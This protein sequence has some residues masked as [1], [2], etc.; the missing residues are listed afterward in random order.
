MEEQMTNL[1]KL[2]SWNEKMLQEESKT[3]QLKKQY[4]DLNSE[5]NDITT[6]TIPKII[7][8]V[9]NQKDIIEKL[10][11]EI[12]DQQKIKIIMDN[13]FKNKLKDHQNEINNLYAIVN[14]LQQTQYIEEN[15][16]TP[17]DT[18]RSKKQKNRM[19]T[20]E[21]MNNNDS[22]MLIIF[23]T[24]NDTATTIEN[25]RSNNLC[26]DE[27]NHTTIIN[28]TNIHNL[29]SNNL[30]ISPIVMDTT[31]IDTS[32][33][34]SPQFNNFNNESLITFNDETNEMTPINLTS[35]FSTEE[36]NENDFNKNK[37]LGNHSP[38]YDT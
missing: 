32:A 31:V 24:G 30:P 22:S 29:E 9:L 38:G 35:H 20:V 4:E 25:A 18:R 27:H 19:P 26:N 17:T 10:K 13:T 23:E 14:S 33:N 7:K 21:R 5:I 12:E 11:Q 37:D 36:N 6:V 34:S 8:S 2:E 15:Q 1:D 16:T 28:N 3:N